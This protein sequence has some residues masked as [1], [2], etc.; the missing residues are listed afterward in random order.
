MRKS[1]LV[2]ILAV[3]V[4]TSAP[5]LAGGG[6]TGVYPIG[7]C[8]NVCP[9]GNCTSLNPIGNLEFTDKVVYCPG[10]TSDPK[11]GNWITLGCLHCNDCCDD[12]YDDGYD[13]GCDDGYDD[14]YDDGCDD[15]CDDCGCGNK[16]GWHD[17]E[18]TWI[19]LPDPIKFTYRGTQQL[20][21]DG[22]VGNIYE[23]GGRLD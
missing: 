15:C 2:C 22:V 7:N 4:L 16:W 23:K 10:H 13:D 14:G 8:T 17:R 6:N 9:I 18:C 3:L 5:A 21:Y 1:L 11:D 12:C 19:Q 20:Q